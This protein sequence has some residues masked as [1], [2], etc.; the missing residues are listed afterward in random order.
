MRSPGSRSAYLAADGA[1]ASQIGA[2]AAVYPA[3]WGSVSSAP[4]GSPTT[5]AASRSSPSECSSREW[6]SLCSS[7]AAGFRPLS[8]GDP[9][10]RRNRDGVPDP[11]R[12]RLRRSRATR[13]GSGC[14]H[15]PLL[16]RHGLRRGSAHGGSSL[17]Q[18]AMAARSC[19]WPHSPPR[20]GSGSPSPV[21]GVRHPPFDLTADGTSHIIGRRCLPAPNDDARRSSSQRPRCRSRADR[22]RMR[23][24]RWRMVPC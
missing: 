2:V 15:L 12:R 9:P 5:S 13:P 1:S 19:S 8:R 16:A 20:A 14:W 21:A 4:A 17:T 7:R 23:T 22:R 10:R 6:H 3:V 18:R 24:W 11:D